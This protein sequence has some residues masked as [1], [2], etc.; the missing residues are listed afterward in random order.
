M[1]KR[2]HR[3]GYHVQWHKSQK[4]PA[5]AEIAEVPVSKKVS[6]K[7]AD[8][9]VRIPTDK[10][11]AKLMDQELA[12]LSEVETVKVESSSRDKGQSPEKQN[13][14]RLKTPSVY[15]N[16][17]VVSPIES[18]SVN[19]AADSGGALKTIGWV[20]VILGLIFLLIISI[21]LGALLMLL[22]LVF[23]VAAPSAD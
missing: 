23:I 18:S 21:L 5:R 2:V 11:P 10:Q 8:L 17:D 19:S 22:G 13:R 3:P 20:L 1:E 12:S 16:V 6:E 15:S 14:L 7:F 4:K 9:D